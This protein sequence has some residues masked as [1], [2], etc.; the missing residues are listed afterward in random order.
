MEEEDKFSKYFWNRFEEKHSFGK[1]FMQRVF[2]KA[3]EIWRDVSPTPFEKVDI[4]MTIE[5]SEFRGTVSSFVFLAAVGEVILEMLGELLPSIL[6][7]AVE[8]IAKQAKDATLMELKSELSKYII[9]PKKCTRCGYEN[10]PTAKYCMECGYNFE[11]E[12]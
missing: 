6:D 9:L 7:E 11:V 10:P 5:E 8:H 1:Y 2:E 12:E 4:Y 3:T